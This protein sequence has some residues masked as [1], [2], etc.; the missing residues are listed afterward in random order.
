MS[1]LDKLA[2]ATGASSEAA[3]IA[4]NV[5]HALNTK[6]GYGAVREAFGLGRYDMYVASKPLV[7]ELIAE[8]LE[9]I[10]RF[11]PRLGDPSISLVGQDRKFWVRFVLEGTVS[12]EKQRFSIRMHSIF[13]NVEVDVAR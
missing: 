1:F 2:G 8:M 12:G 11:E 10:D 9:V 5:Q 4:Q 13:R 6:R 7:K 3:G